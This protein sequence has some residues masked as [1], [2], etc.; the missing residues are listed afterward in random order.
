[1][2][3]FLRIFLLL[4]LVVIGGV[5]W[6]WYV[7]NQ[8]YK[9]FQDSVFLDLPPR[10]RT[11]EMAQLLAS[12][13]VIQSAW[14][15]MAARALSPHSVLQAGEYK[16]EQPASPFQVFAR[17]A[18]GDTYYE[19]LTVPEG[20]NI[21]D[22]AALLKTLDLVSPE[23]FLKA[24]RDPSLIKDLDSAA[25]SLEGYLFPDSYRLNRKTT[26]AQLC[27]T[28]TARFRHEWQ[29]LN[30]TANVHDTITL[31]SLVEREARQPQER[32]LVASVFMNRLKIGMKLDCDPTT[33]YAALLENRF[34]GTI[35]KSDLASTHPY[36]TY[37][38]PGLPPGPIANPGLSSIKAAL[39]PAQTD[40]LY[41]VAKSDGTGS[42]TFSKDLVGHLA[43]SQ[44]ARTAEGA[45]Q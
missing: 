6:V 4:L 18:R 33:V 14:M 3:T 19:V 43:A 7:L 20:Q 24:A 12:R 42:H 21:F 31:A 15:F 34:R 32:E 26:A 27:R 37:Q 10:T 44:L 9:G 39:K 1:M 13:G 2:K 35:Y 28:M 29:S 17:I 22:I 11:S 36:N 40:F 8:P 5:A 38:H 41:F 16:F 30:T 23:E 25:P 45:K